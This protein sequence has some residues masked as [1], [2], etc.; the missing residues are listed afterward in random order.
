MLNDSSF[1]TLKT[2]HLEE[3]DLAC[4]DFSMYSK[5]ERVNLTRNSNLVSFSFSSSIQTL[6]AGEMAWSRL[7]SDLANIP[8]L[9][10]LD[11]SGCKNLDF[12]LDFD[13]SKLKA[14]EDLTMDDCV[15]S[16]LPI[17]LSLIKNLA[18]ISV[19][20][21]RIT[22]QGL[23]EQLLRNAKSLHTLALQGNPGM[24]E[25]NFMECPGVE[26]YL[27]R[28]KGRIDKQIAGGAYGVQLSLL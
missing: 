15:L 21:N 2:V 6:A 3:N 1:H 16:S 12:I 27:K 28:R 22:P 26:E 8:S 23:P 14:L 9:R 20:R 11:I 18:V 25:A 10:S 5:L 13:F 4:V 19:K 17:S 7:P 24:T